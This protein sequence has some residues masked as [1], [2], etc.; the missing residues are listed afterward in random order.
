MSEEL[1]IKEGVFE[2]MLPPKSTANY[3]PGFELGLE[4][5]RW[6]WYRHEVRVGWY[7]I[8]GAAHCKQT[9]EMLYRQVV[10]QL[11]GHSRG[12][13]LTDEMWETIKDK[14]CSSQT[15]EFMDLYRDVIAEIELTR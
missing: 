9:I 10:S 1:T 7:M 3:N 2:R 13:R 12:A 8:D 4:I 11:G 14:V 15:A 6:F 5:V